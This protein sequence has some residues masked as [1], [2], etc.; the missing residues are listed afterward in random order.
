VDP[1]LAKQVIRLAQTS[2]FGYN[3]H[4]LTELPADR[5]GLGSRIANVILRMVDRAR[6]PILES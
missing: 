6:N 2:Y 3:R 1:D 4:H 5:E